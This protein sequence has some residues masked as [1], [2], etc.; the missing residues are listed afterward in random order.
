MNHRALYT[1]YSPSVH[2]IVPT[3]EEKVKGSYVYRK[4]QLSIFEV[5]H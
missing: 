5:E 4:G 1:L 2:Q 3:S